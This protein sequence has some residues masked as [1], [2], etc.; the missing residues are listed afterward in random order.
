MAPTVS[1]AG[2]AFSIRE[3]HSS[4]LPLVRAIL[5]VPIHYDPDAQMHLYLAIDEMEQRPL[6]ASLSIPYGEHIQVWVEVLPAF[7]RQGI[8]TCLF[9]QVEKDL[10]AS[11]QELT[12]KGVSCSA[13]DAF[14]QIQGFHRL[15]KIV[16]FEAKIDDYLKYFEK[17]VERFESRGVIPAEVRGYYGAEVDLVGVQQ[18][19]SPLFGSSIQEALSRMIAYGVSQR[20]WLYELR[21]GDQI[22]G[23]VVGHFDNKSVCGDAYVIEPSFRH[24]WAQMIFK[25]RAVSDA[26]TRKPWLKTFR[27]SAGTGFTDTLKWGRRI[28]A[29]FLSSQWLYERNAPRA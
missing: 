2:I 27:A 8:G 6:G 5:Q 12:H 14:A 25:H 23:A 17:W 18:L 7:R 16:S 4:E 26:L 29:T 19:V 9:N 10:V 20:D 1:S 13:G 21:L 24:G 11:K 3:I 28:N 15:R 22:I